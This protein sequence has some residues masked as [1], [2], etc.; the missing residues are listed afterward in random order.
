MIWQ[1]IF[2][3]HLE[4]SAFKINL[5]W[6]ED[7]LCLNMRT[8]EAN[9]ELKSLKIVNIRRHMCKQRS[10]LWQ[11]KSL[12]I[13]NT[14]K[15]HFIQ[16]CGGFFPEPFHR[17]FFQEAQQEFLKFFQCMSVHLPVPSLQIVS[18]IGFELMTSW[19]V[20]N[21]IPHLTLT[22]IICIKGFV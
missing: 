12:C 5:K 18:S 10:T 22:P 13:W 19:L 4:L 20:L 2:L 8:S 6:S 21:A 14:R 11:Q 17:Y 3:I 16:N 1:Y 7:V 15:R 9:I